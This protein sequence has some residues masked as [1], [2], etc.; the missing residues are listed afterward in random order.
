MYFVFFLL[1]LD[2]TCTSHSSMVC[3]EDSLEE[4]WMGLLGYLSRISICKKKKG[5]RQAA[6]FIFETWDRGLR[7]WKAGELGHSTGSKPC[8]RKPAFTEGTEA[9]SH[10]FP[11]SQGRG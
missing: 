1:C 3:Q 2:D 7:N 10:G 4:E 11:K 8:L 6:A 5:K 9:Y